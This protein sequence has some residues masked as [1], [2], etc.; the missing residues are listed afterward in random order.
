MAK[1][2]SEYTTLS[3]EEMLERYQRAQSLRQGFKSKVIA[4]N[5]TLIPH[6]VGESDCFW[7]ERDHQQ[8]KEYRLVDA[9]KLSNNIAFDHQV[10]AD[11][12]AETSQQPV[13]ACDLPISKLEWVL[14]PLQITF[15][16]FGKRWQFTAEGGR[17]VELALYP[18]E[19]LISPDGKQ[20]ALGHEYNVWVRDLAT[21]QERQLTNDG[22]LLYPYALSPTARGHRSNNRVEAVWSP[23]SKRLFTLQE[24]S[25]SVK[26]LPLIDYV[27]TDGSL[28]PRVMVDRRSALPDD[29]NIHEYRFLSIEVATGKHQ[30]ADYQRVPVF[31][32]ADGYFSARHGW[33]SEDNRHA[34]FIDIVRGGDHTARFVEFDTHTG[35]TRVLIEEECTDTFFK[36]RLDS[37]LPIHTRSLPGS[38]DLLWFSERSG[39]GHLYL[40]DIKTGE[41]KHP[42]TEGEWVVR[43]IHHYDPARRE[44]VIQTSGRIDDR[45]AY[46]RDICRVNIDTG[47]LTPI[48]ATDDEY[49]VF[50]QNTEQ[51][52]NLGTV[53][54]IHEAKGVSPTGHYLVTTRSRADT[55]PVSLLLDRGGNELLTLETADVSGLPY[56]WQWPEPVKLLGAD[57][58]TDIYGVVYRPSHF[59]PDQIYPILDYSRD[60]REG[61]YLPAGSFTNN[62]VAG[63][64]YLNPAALAELGFI[65]VDICG[66]GT[67][68]RSRSFSSAVQ[69]ELPN[70]EA[71]ADRVA[72]I[73]QL[74]ERYPYMDINRVGAGARVSSAVAISSLLGQPDFYKVGVAIGACFDLRLHQA[75][76]SEPYADMPTTTNNLTTAQQ[77]ANNLKGKLL[78][79]HGIKSPAVTVAQSFSL[80]DAL[81]KANKDFDMLMLPNDAYGGSNYTVRRAWDYLVTHLLGTEP[82]PCFTLTLSVTK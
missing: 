5:T 57:S 70:S 31:R 56:G 40:Y 21:G 36:L 19:W 38:D 66:R 47:E 34:Y 24:D 69:I 65:V 63:M 77:L 22:E 44:L 50:D 78:I 7:Y 17:C 10:F 49:V 16:A 67:M 75:F 54:D 71:E 59:S 45:H 39:W 4:F 18:K 64:N 14:S 73:R 72:G 12:L 61:G 9:A 25:R 52:A 29:E 26:S 1:Q 35:A 51:A 82:P 81:Q 74:A 23:D 68:N 6:W 33:W 79:I 43:D 46:Y 8:G 30:D 11:A 37:R 41:F 55:V 80:I 48:I 3:Q 20:A 32:N 27:P 15:N 42:I 2:Q 62:S 13:D 28:R 58:K 76:F 53:R 60:T